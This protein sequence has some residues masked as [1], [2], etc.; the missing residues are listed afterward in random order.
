M[1]GLFRLETL[2][3]LIEILTDREC[4]ALAESKHIYFRLL[5]Y[6]ATKYTLK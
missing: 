1:I 3:L 2:D 6:S 4:Q 5:K